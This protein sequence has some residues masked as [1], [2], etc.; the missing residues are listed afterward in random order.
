MKTIKKHPTTRNNTCK[1]KQTEN[2][3]K[4]KNRK[5]ICKTKRNQ[6]FNRADK[7]SDFKTYQSRIFLNYGDPESSDGEEV[8]SEVSDL[9]DSSYDE[10]MGIPDNI[11]NFENSKR[12]I[13]CKT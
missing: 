9:S 12:H 7:P 5:R 11:L 2:Y 10:L 4:N 8:L 1:R 6:H 3:R 13:K